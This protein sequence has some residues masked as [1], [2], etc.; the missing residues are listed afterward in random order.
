VDYLKYGAEINQ[1]WKDS[2]GGMGDPKEREKALKHVMDWWVEN[3]GMLSK[4]KQS[5]WKVIV[6]TMQHGADQFTGLVRLMPLAYKMELNIEQATAYHNLEEIEAF[7]LLVYVGSDPVA[8]QKSMVF[9]RSENIK[10]LIKSSKVDVWCFLDNVT[11]A[12][13]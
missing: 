10:K 12:L 13:K 9:S 6:N 3:R 2:V 1:A 8:H 7:G 4:D 5:S 11:T